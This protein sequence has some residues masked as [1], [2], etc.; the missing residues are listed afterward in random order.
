MLVAT[1]QQIVVSQS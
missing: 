1:D